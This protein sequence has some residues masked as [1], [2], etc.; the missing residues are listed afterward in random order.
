MKINVNDIEKVKKAI[1]ER[2]G[3]ARSRTFDPQEIPKIIKEAEKKLVSLE[4][5]KKYWKG[6][7]IFCEPESVPNSYKYSAEG[8]F[9][10]IVRYSTGW[11]V[12]GAGRN[13]CKK[14][15]YGAHSKQELS[16]SQ[17]AFDAIPS[18]Y[19]VSIY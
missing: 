5:P 2:E 1:D 3:K 4:I 13:W 16:L 10:N 18:R 8:T 17:N 12:T 6:C 9:V 15:A 19:D 14:C 11:F 7:T